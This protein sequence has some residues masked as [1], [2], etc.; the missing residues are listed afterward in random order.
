MTR[1]ILAV[2][3][4]F[5]VRL[6]LETVM[7]KS[8]FDVECVERGDECISFLEENEFKGVILMDLMMP[9][10]DGWETI[11][12]IVRRE[13]TGNVIILVLTAKPNPM[14]SE[15]NKWLIGHVEDFIMKPFHNI[16]LINKIN[17]IFMKHPHIES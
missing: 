8:G 12:E 4:E 10:M 9:D 16:E 1:R 3:D 11:Y 17:D 14:P 6:T 5:G 15:G 7:E 13:L 2:D